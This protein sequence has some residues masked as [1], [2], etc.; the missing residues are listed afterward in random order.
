MGATGAGLVAA[1]ELQAE[2]QALGPAAPVALAVAEAEVLVLDR[3][4]AGL[5]FSV[6][7]TERLALVEA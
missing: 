2:E 5:A 7:Y 3:S 4:I 6:A 1:T